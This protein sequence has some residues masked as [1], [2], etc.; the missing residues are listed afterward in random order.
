MGVFSLSKN[1]T[2]RLHIVPEPMACGRPFVVVTAPAPAQAT[3]EA[4]LAALADAGVSAML[5]HDRGCGCGWPDRTGRHLLAA[6]LE[7]GGLVMLAFETLADAMA[8]HRRLQ[9]AAQ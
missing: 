8:C 9:D 1:I 3:P 5:T 7:Q 2:T 6:T 4:F